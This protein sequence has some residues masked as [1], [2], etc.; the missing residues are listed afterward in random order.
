MLLIYNE[1]ESVLDTRCDG[2]YSLTIYHYKS[3]SPGYIHL[4]EEEERGVRFGYISASH[5]DGDKIAY[6]EQSSEG[7]LYIHCNGRKVPATMISPYPSKRSWDVIYL[8]ISGTKISALGKV[9][10]QHFEIKMVQVEFEL[11]YSYFDRLHKALDLLPTLTVQRLIPT[12]R[13]HFC[14]TKQQGPSL[15]LQ[16]RFK[17]FLTLDFAQREALE[18]IVFAEAGAP[19]IIA[20]SFGTGKTQLLA[21]AAYQILKVKRANT[22]RP[23][24]LVCAHHQA[25]ADAFLVKYFGPMIEEGWRVRMIRMIVRFSDKDKFEYQYRQY[26]MT[27]REVSRR[28]H[29]FELVVTTFANCLHLATILKDSS[30]GFFTHILVDEGAQTREPETIAPLFLSGPNTVIAIAGDHKQVSIHS[31]WSHIVIIILLSPFSCDR[32]A[33]LCWC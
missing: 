20:G 2:E 16:H 22:P 32:L 29:S 28:I 7:R 4:S 11:K 13:N 10:K 33:L 9:P 5:L 25:S 6:A 1:L 18:A 24:V 12:S 17:G 30:A 26:C 15:S 23:R 19:V 14:F 3:E 8:S 27:A 31:I 21:Q